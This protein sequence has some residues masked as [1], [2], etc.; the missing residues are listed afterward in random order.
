MPML[1]DLFCRSSSLQVLDAFYSGKHLRPPTEHSSAV[2]LVIQQ[3]A[4]PQE[5]K[6]II[7]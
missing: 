3:N 1:C 4:C 5:H 2:P 6:C 7:S